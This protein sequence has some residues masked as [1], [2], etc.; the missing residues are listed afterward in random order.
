M[1]IGGID[2]RHVLETRAAVDGL[3]GIARRDRI[4]V[5]AVGSGSIGAHEGIGEGAIRV[6]V[7]GGADAIA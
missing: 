5:R 1:R 2:H 3:K 6:V 4:P 7:G